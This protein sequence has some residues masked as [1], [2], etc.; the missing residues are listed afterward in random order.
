MGTQII[1]QMRTAATLL[2]LLTVLT[3]II[4]PLVVTGCLQTLFPWQANG[5]LLRHGEVIIGSALIGQ[6]FVSAKYFWGRPSATSPTP[7]N[8]K[9]SAGSNLGAANPDLLIAVQKRI[10]V[11]L[12]AD[13]QNNLPI[14]IGLVT[15]SA[16]GLDPDISLSDAFY[17]LPRVAKARGVADKIIKNSILHVSENNLWDI[18]SNARVNVLRLNLALDSLETDKDMP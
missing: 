12:K 5:S 18:M 14:P 4:Y 3:G 1:Q 17:Q 16:S 10:D 6:E 13:P 15:A 9:N 11:L 8:S 7:Y 2:G